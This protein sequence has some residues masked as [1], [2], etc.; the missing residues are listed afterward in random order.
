MNKLAFSVLLALG[1]GGTALAQSP[2]QLG[3]KGGASLASYAGPDAGGTR[4]LWGGLAGLTLNAPISADKTLSVQ[5]E[6][7]YSQKGFRPAN[8]QNEAAGRRLHYL[9]V[10]VLAR[11]NAYGFI[12]EAGPQA[13]YLLGTS[14]PGPDGGTENAGPLADNLRRLDLGYAAGVG[15]QGGSG[16]GG[17]LRYNGG[18]RSVQADAVRRNSAFQLFASYTFV[19]R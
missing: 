18:L 13:G 2:V 6:L 16:I 11:V 14:Q 5:P 4:G 1:A 9:D 15:Y 17:G 8:G 19:G 12:F 7:L 10:P 3:V